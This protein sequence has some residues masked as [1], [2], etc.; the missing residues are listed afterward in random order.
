MKKILAIFMMIMLAAGCAA[1]AQETD[2][3]DAGVSAEGWTASLKDGKVRIVD[4]NGIELATFSYAKDEGVQDILVL[5]DY[6]FDGQTDLAALSGMGTVNAYYTVWLRTAQGGFEEAPE[7]EGLCSPIVN[8][9]R[10]RIST[11]ERVGAQEYY[12]GAYGW[13]NGELTM[14]RMRRTVYE[15]DGTVS[16]TDQIQ[17]GDSITEHSYQETSEQWDKITAREIK[18]DALVGK[19]FDAPDC[20]LFVIYEGMTDLN[21]ESYFTYSVVKNSE[22]LSVM[23]ISAADEAVV[24][25]DEEMDEIAQPQWI[26][27]ETGAKTEIK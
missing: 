18:A 19:L 13:I 2:I 23:Y 21:G 22:K 10:A 5:K 9:E 11:I 20:Q 27:D 25:L 26:L 12:E 14:L 15:N 17:T 16:V 24:L 6:N 7:F 1:F 4:A 3:G 8:A